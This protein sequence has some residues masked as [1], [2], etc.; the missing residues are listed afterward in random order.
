MVAD[1]QIVEWSAMEGLYLYQEIHT[2]D[3]LP[4][5]NHISLRCGHPTA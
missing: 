3:N 2:L 1:G 4:I 5:G